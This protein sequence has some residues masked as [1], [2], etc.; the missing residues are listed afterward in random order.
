MPQFGAMITVLLFLIL[1]HNDCATAF[2]IRSSSRARISFL[3]RMESPLSHVDNIIIGL[4]P[5]E[6]SIQKS[7][8]ELNGIDEVDYVVIG[9]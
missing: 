6:K 9:R 5:P 3:N 8:N 1:L 7:E 2:T 4:E